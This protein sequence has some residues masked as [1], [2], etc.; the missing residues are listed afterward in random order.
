MATSVTHLLHH[1]SSAIL[2]I[3]KANVITPIHELS[4][5]D[6]VTDYEWLSKDAPCYEGVP[7]ICISGRQHI[8]IAIGRYPLLGDDPAATL[9]DMGGMVDLYKPFILTAEFDHSSGWPLGL[10]FR[11]LGEFLSVLA[12]E[13]VPYQYW[14]KLNIVLP[15]VELPYDTSAPDLIPL[16]RLENLRSLEW[17]GHRKQLGPTEFIL[18]PS[19]A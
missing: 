1:A 4:E 17:S 16:E 6:I 7:L 2:S 13:E 14:N 10:G 9:W 15:H 11:R 19:M 5:D 8:E 12:H 18:D 3:S